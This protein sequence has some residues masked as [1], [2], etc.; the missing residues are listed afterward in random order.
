MI[1]NG[2]AYVAVAVRDVEEVAQALERDFLLPRIDCAVGTSQ[3]QAPGFSVGRTNLALFELGD[4]FV[5]DAEKTG[6]H[7]LAV[8]VDDPAKAGELAAESGVPTFSGKTET[9]LG[10]AARLL[11][12]P[13]ATGGVITYLSEPLKQTH[14][15]TAASSSLVERIDHVGGGQPRQPISAGRFSPAVWL[16]GGKHPNRRR[17]GHHS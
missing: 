3:R 16:A 12:E 14:S 17:D 7:H 13:S 5:R 1:G 8:S 6:V 4:P 9:G 10:G 15:D 2:L 11:L